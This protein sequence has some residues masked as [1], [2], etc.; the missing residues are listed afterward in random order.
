[1]RCMLTKSDFVTIKKIV[2]E[3]VNNVVKKVVK[4]EVKDQL[5]SVKIEL[6]SDIATFKDTMVSRLNKIDEEL[7]IL[8]GYK[9]Q[10]ED[11]ADRLIKL[12][13]I[14]PQGKHVKNAS[15]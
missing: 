5:E 3:V 12:E 9:D 13:D 14:H 10:R 7:I 6:K 11:Y 15:I 8:N 1:M 4:E 2:N